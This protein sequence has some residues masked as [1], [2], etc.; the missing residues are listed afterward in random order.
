MVTRRTGR[1]R[2]NA[3]IMSDLVEASSMREEEL[4]FVLEHI[5]GK[6][7]AITAFKN[8]AIKS[9]FIFADE[10]GEITRAEMV[11]QAGFKAHLAKKEKELRDFNSRITELYQLIRDTPEL[12][13]NDVPMHL[14]IALEYCLKRNY[15]KR[16]WF[17]HLIKIIKDEPRLESYS[18]I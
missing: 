16:T 10:L 6:P 18:F 3:Q 13:M 8:F 9:K 1:D 15:L 5:K 12:R 11:R 17:K 2:T 14:H 4:L 7:E